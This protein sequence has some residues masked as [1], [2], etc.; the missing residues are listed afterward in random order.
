MLLFDYT[1][2]VQR[3]SNRV[4]LENLCPVINKPDQHLLSMAD[5]VSE[6]TISH[7][8]SRFQGKCFMRVKTGNISDCLAP[9]TDDGATLE[10]E[11]MV[12]DTRIFSIDH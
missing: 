5:D 12:V 1:L 11:M 7:T 9:V 4:V 3:N 10:K 6:H 8:M 2:H